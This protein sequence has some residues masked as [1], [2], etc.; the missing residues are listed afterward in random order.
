MSWHAYF[1]MLACLAAIGVV[2]WLWSVFRKDVSIV[3]SLWSLMFLV[4]AIGYALQVGI[5]DTRGWIILVFCAAW[6]LRLSWYITRR[7]H[8]DGEDLRYQAIRKNNEPNFWLKS[9]YIV[10]GLQAL[11]AWLVAMPLAAAISGGKPF[12]LLDVL[13]I[14]LWAIGMF[15]EVVGDR[16]LA[17][18]KADPANKG[19]VLDTGLWRYTRHPNYF[20]EFT[21]WWGFYLLAAGA[22][23]WWTIASPILM[24]VLLLRVSGVTMLEKTIGDRRPAY[25]AYIQRT[26]AF[27]PGP[28]RSAA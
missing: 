22:G 17:R 12:G 25:A 15:F 28:P 4:V 3:D 26:N 6:S 14:S 20:G 19:K 7:N 9:L 27:F 24:S 23:G 8:G 2:F 18:F 5:T 11:L 1:V 21:L 10:F 16:Q 13:G